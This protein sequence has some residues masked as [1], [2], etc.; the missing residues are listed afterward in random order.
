M[1][2]TLF[3][4]TR[5][6]DF[7]YDAEFDDLDSARGAVR[8]FAFDGGYWLKNDTIFVPWHSVDY[9]RMKEKVGE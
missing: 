9:A 2:V 3:I 4:R 6:G 7:N 5:D 8:N 1:S